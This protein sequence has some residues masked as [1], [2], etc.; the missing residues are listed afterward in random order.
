MYM[1]L[2]KINVIYELFRIRKMKKK[3]KHLSHELCLPSIK[4][5][6]LFVITAGT[7]G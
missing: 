6:V 4:L 7:C 2:E 1:K 5:L 3:K